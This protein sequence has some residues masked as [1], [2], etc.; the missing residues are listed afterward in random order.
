MV[1]ERKLCRKQT[2]KGHPYMTAVS[3]TSYHNEFYCT[4]YTSVFFR[5]IN[6]QAYSLV[7]K[8]TVLEFKT[9]SRQFCG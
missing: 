5:S 7:K 8:K 6:M 3:S 1:C 4:G 2:Q 9:L